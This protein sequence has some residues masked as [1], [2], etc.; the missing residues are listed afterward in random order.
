MGGHRHGACAAAPQLLDSVAMKR[1][2]LLSLVLLTACGAGD[3]GGASLSDTGFDTSVADT[4]PTDAATDTTVFDTTPADTSVQDTTDTREAPLFGL[5]SDERFLVPGNIAAKTEV[6]AGGN[7]VAWVEGDDPPLL[8]VW[9]VTDPTAAP[10]SFS[11][12]TLAHPR[13][14]ALSDAW[15]AYVD[16]RYGDP[17]VFAIDLRTGAE[18]TVA[19]GPGAQ[20]APAVLGGR[21]AWEDCG[22]CVTGAGLPGQEPAR[23]IVEREL[24]DGA[25]EA[26]TADAFADRAPAYGLLADGRAALVWLRDRAT[27]R[28]EALDQSA[29]VSRTTDVSASL[30]PDQQVAAVALT[31]GL[32]AWRPNPLIVNPDSMIV[33][34]D[35]MY[36]SD[37]F[38]TDEA[39][40][41]T[42]LTVHA[43]HAARLSIAVRTL[44]V[45]VAWLESAPGDPTLGRVRIDDG[46]G[47]TT[48]AEVPGLT[49]FALGRGGIVFAAPRADNDGLLDVHV[50][51]LDLP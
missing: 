46:T 30:R 37:L 44:G 9:D 17:D 6:A 28:V 40:V 45:R 18:L 27:L 4:I 25:P 31:E 13:A 23:E 41:T 3:D 34:P 8:V 26:R 20:E 16:D 33:N 32:V 7:L 47:P 43:E 14:L 22:A 19:G 21:A 11:P 2:A 29:G 15:L 42:A 35:S 48:V 1:L 50:L 51:I 38:T 24:P 5:K 10:R 39:G 12:P 49:T 36:P